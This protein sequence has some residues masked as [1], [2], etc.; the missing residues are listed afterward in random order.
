M[1]HKN[2]VFDIGLTKNYNVGVEIKRTAS[3]S[4]PTFFYFIG[5]SDFGED[6]RKHMFTERVLDKHVFGHGNKTKQVL[7]DVKALNASFL[8]Q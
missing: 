2:Q 5:N 3:V 8:S 7:E 4:A 1:S 6:K